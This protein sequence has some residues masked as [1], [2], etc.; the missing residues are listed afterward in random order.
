M[1][2]ETISFRETGYFSELICDYLDGK[3]ELAPFYNRKPELPNFKLQ[4]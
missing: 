1:D 4:M 3:E 2:I